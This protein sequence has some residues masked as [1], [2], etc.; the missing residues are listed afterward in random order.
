[1]GQNRL[2]IAVD[3][4]PAADRAIQVGLDLAVAQSATATFAHVTDKARGLLK[5]QPAADPTE[6]QLLRL[7]AVLASAMEAART[8]GVRADVEIAD[9]N[10]AD[11]VAGA[12]VGLAQARGASM[13]V[14]GTRGRG[15]LVSSVLGSVSHELLRTAP[16]P[17]VVVNASTEGA[18]EAR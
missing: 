1:M 5:R 16:V 12:I 9:A 18:A 11:G 13:I 10:G 14:V 17:V 6:E 4:S 7:D 8:R 15:A 2:L 3:G